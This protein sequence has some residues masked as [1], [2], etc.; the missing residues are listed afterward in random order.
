MITL[1]AIA[2]LI[3]VGGLFVVMAVTPM[4]AE[5]EHRKAPAPQSL[6]SPERPVPVSPRWDNHKH[7]A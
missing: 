4:V 2:L 7:A 1:L 3:I 5:A 6:S